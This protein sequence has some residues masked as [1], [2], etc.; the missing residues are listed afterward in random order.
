[1]SSA[2]VFRARF[3]CLFPVLA[4]RSC[5]LVRL[6][7]CARGVPSRK[8]ADLCSNGR[9]NR[10]GAG[11]GRRPVKQDETTLKR[12]RRS[13][14]GGGEAE[15]APASRRRITRCRTT[16]DRGGGS[17]SSSR[18]WRGA[19]RACSSSSGARIRG[20]GG[21][22]RSRWGRRR[23]EMAWTALATSS[24][25]APVSPRTSTLASES[26]ARS[27]IRNMR[28]M[29]GSQVSIRWNSTSA[30]EPSET[31]PLSLKSST[32]PTRPSASAPWSGTARAWTRR[33]PPWARGR[34]MATAA[35]RPLARASAMGR[36][37]AWP[38]SSLGAE[39]PRGT[40]SP[41]SCSAP[42]VAARMR[43]CRSRTISA[44][45]SSSR[46]RR[47]AGATGAGP[48][49]TPGEDASGARR[50]RAA[51]SHGR[52]RRRE[53]ATTPAAQG[54]DARSTAPISRDP[55]DLDR[56]AQR[57]TPRGWAARRFP[58]PG[59]WKRARRGNVR[60]RGRC[61]HD[62]GLACPV[63]SLF[64]ITRPTSPELPLQRHPA[65]RLLP[66]R[67]EELP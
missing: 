48:S 26:A 53:G 34:G 44:P 40:G 36:S 19:I 7:A 42:G 52:S 8:A 65:A 50:T 10:G 37:T 14:V 54:S 67:G 57:V 6:C 51:T 12:A 43:R 22:Q 31:A 5:A 33:S 58:C 38:Q 35:E 45:P 9:R 32:Q 49:R 3:L 61:H 16:T 27:R 39:R 18:G 28:F 1:M 20:W 25:P 23:G 17:G 41:R 21:S 30:S 4:T 56:Q 24:L 15:G 60:A 47:T 55:V 59:D 29:A 46:A 13:A 11:R 2:P 64:Q 63:G 66:R 62:A